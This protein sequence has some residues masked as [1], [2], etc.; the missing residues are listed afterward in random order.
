MNRGVNETLVAYL[1]RMDKY[2]ETQNTLIKAQVEGDIVRNRAQLEFNKQQDVYSQQQV[3][4]T[5]MLA[6]ATKA[7]TF[8][9]QVH[10]IE[11]FDGTK[12]EDYQK[13][14]D[15]VEAVA[16]VSNIYAREIATARSGGD[17]KTFIIAFP[18]KTDW[19]DIKVNLKENFSSNP[20]LAH[21]WASLQLIKQAHDENMSLYI[22][23]FSKQ[24]NAYVAGNRG[25]TLPDSMLKHQFLQGV[26]NPYL[27]Q[28]LA[29]NIETLTLEELQK[30]ARKMESSNKYYEGLRQGQA[31][32]KDLPPMGINAID[33]SA[34][35]GQNGQQGKPA[36]GRQPFQGICY[37]CGLYGHMGRD[38]QKSKDAETGE[39]QVSNRPVGTITHTMN[40]KTPV[41]EELSRLLFEKLSKQQRQLENMG[42]KFRK[43]T[44]PPKEKEVTASKENPT[45]KEANKEKNNGKNGK[46][47]NGKN[48]AKVT[49][50]YEP[51]QI[52]AAAYEALSS[53]AETDEE[54]RQAFDLA[55]SMAEDAEITHD[56][57]G[58]YLDESDT[59]TE[60]STEEVS[61]EAGEDSE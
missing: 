6:Q 46:A 51:G 48:D 56:P 50:K 37:R 31:D 34:V 49:V 18:P 29:E 44:Q 16:A 38:C 22:A 26:R 23:R 19:S 40:L 10:D 7:R 24:V 59:T 60:G 57:Y 45:P 2:M 15:Q 55:C 27:G 25:I 53:M 5:Q 47:K 32:T 52:Q 39:Q 43:N 61:G 42:K 35:Q 21:E 20:T 11:R 3:E 1:D 28:K 30:K 33:V 36:G 41:S 13:W 14:I 17:V 8:D 58:I 54:R 12:P 4:A 9:L